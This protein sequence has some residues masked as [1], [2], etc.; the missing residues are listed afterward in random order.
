MKST[1][2]TILVLLIF[3]SDSAGQGLGDDLLLYY[4]FDGTTDDLSDN[5]YHGIPFG[6]QYV[7]DRFGNPDGA[8][9]FDGNNDYVNFP[10]LDELKPDLPVSFSFWIKYDSPSFQDRAVFNTSFE[11][12]VNTGVFLT[13]RSSQNTYAMGYGDGDPVYDNSSIRAYASNTEIE[14]DEWVHVAIVVSGP[15]NMKIYINCEENGGSYNGFGGELVYSDLPGCVGRHDQNTGSVEAYYFDGAIDDFRY[16]SRALS[17]DEIE[18]LCVDEEYD[19]PN[20]LAD[21]GDECDSNGENG[22]IN[23]DCECNTIIE[24]SDFQVFLSDIAED[25]STTL[26][27]LSIANNS[28]EL[29]PLTTFGDER[30]IAYNSIDQLVYTVRKSDGAFQTISPVDAAI[31]PLVSLEYDLE[32]VTG[33]AFDNEGDLL[34]LSQSLNTIFACD[35]ESGTV[36]TYDSYSPVLGGDIEVGSDGGIFLS[37]REDFGVL[38][39]AIPP[40]EGEDVLLGDAPQFVTGLSTTV[41]GQLFFSELGS[42]ELVVVDL[43]GTFVG[44]LPL[45]LN[46]EPFVCGNGDLA[47]GCPNEINIETTAA[48][49]DIRLVPFP[50]PASFEIRFNVNLDII[51]EINISAFSLI[52][53]SHY[54]LLD[55]KLL[56]G[57]HEIVLDVSELPQGIYILKMQSASR[58]VSSKLIISR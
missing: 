54:E 21:I 19:C 39:R 31:G 26:Y 24:C 44:T 46:G 49:F 17:E 45:S 33:A 55:D 11:E 40:S 9:S 43:D 35:I 57:K 42:D 2:L 20:F 48:P 32:E 25:E 5:D 38:Y 7:D 16:W 15:T 3:I 52:D 30:H 34:L 51:E 6:I 23:E 37:T 28:G 1:F 36:E 13:S 41:E 29:S 47:S 53:F 10:N 14:I 8:A 58:S 22:I 56:K 4:P 12:N 50:N 18:A 27:S